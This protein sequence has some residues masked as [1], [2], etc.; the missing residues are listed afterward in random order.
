MN[1]IFRLKWVLLAG[2]TLGILTML[3]LRPTARQIR[4]AMHVA[5]AASVIAL[6]TTRLVIG[7]TARRR[8]AAGQRE[9]RPADIGPVLERLSVA[10]RSLARNPTGADSKTQVL[11]ELDSLIALI[12]GPS[13]ARAASD[14]KAARAAIAAA[15]PETVPAALDLLN[16]ALGKGPDRKS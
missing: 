16:P 13:M 1:D 12:D 8:E 10:V 2:S 14:L 15:T 4:I 11:L 7:W 5:L 6:L 9:P 3:V